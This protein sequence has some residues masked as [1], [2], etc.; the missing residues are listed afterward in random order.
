VWTI[1]PQ[2]FRGAHFAT[3]PEKLVEPC[4]LAGTS[5]AGQCVECGSPCYRNT[6][7]SPMIIDRSERTLEQG[8]THNSGTMLSPP[9]SVT[10]GWFSTCACNADMTPQTVL[11][12]FCG[13]GTTGVVALRHGR[14]FIGIE[15]NEQYAEI[16]R[17]RIGGTCA[18]A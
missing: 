5:T 4:I 2:P 17:N 12:P 15:L 14:Q 3:F 16:A 8:R 1:V 11:D 9:H 6:E 18:V 7:R 13:S 10:L